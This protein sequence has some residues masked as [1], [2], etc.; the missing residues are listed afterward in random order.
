MACSM[1]SDN[2][3]KLLLLLPQ[4]LLLKLLLVCRRDKDL[5]VLKQMVLLCTLLDL[6]PFKR[7]VI[8]ALALL[9]LL[10]ELSNVPELE[11]GH[12][13]ILEKTGL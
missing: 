2:S 8:L 6:A 9:S 4:F 12:D 11:P 7:N 10:L 3:L 1:H 13:V 5:L